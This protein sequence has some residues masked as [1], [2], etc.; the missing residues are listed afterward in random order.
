MMSVTSS[1]TF[2]IVENSCSTL[3]M[4]TDAMAAP[5][6]L[7]RSVRR[8]AFP[9]VYPKPGSS[10]STVNRERVGETTSSSMWG[11]ATISTVLPPAGDHP[12]LPVSVPPAPPAGTGLL[13]VELDD[14]LLPQLRVDGGPAG[15]VGHRDGERPPVHVEPGRDDPRL[16]RL[17]GVVDDQE[18][19]R[20]RSDDDRDLHSYPTR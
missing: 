17:D 16:G 2:G 15:Q 12:F 1:V 9:S 11:L 18:V 13:R 6:M 19:P 14:Q 8:R 5:G 10:G 7:D 4:R 3:S 20:S